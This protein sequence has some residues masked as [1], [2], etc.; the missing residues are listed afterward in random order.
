MSSA[1]KFLEEACEKIDAVPAG[2]EEKP[3]RLK[4]PNCLRRTALPCA[5]RLYVCLNADCPG[6][7]IEESLGRFVL[8]LTVDA[9]HGARLLPWK[10]VGERDRLRRRHPLG[11]LRRL[12]PVFEMSAR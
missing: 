12:L 3:F 8:E 6:N 11:V 1:R 2:E 10:E 5:N 4:C 7:T 9:I